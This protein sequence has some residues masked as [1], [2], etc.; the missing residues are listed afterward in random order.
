MFLALI[1]TS[2]TSHP[3]D[4]SILAMSVRIQVR[5]CKNTGERRLRACSIS[6]TKS[7][8]AL[9]IGASITYG[10]TF[11]TWKFEP[12]AGMGCISCFSQSE[13]WVLR[14]TRFVRSVDISTT[15]FILRPALVL[16]PVSVSVLNSSY[17][18]MALQRPLIQYVTR[19]TDP[20]IDMVCDI[21]LTNGES[22]TILKKARE[23]INAQ[24]AE[25]E[26][27]I[28]RQT[29]GDLKLLN[30]HLKKLK[31][32]KEN[33]HAETQRSPGPEFLLE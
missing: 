33:R 5:C 28:E 11:T 17:Q 23:V 12:L 21:R 22:L 25:L 8:L 20:A 16:V 1:P 7:R 13:S 27:T 15:I 18:P 2:P 26:Q 24:I 4:Q 30:P 29:G 31:R 9:T 32:K 6:I 10:I 3:A 14:I 19:I